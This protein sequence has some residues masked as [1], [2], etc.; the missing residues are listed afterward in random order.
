[1][2]ARSRERA[3]WQRELSAYWQQHP[4]TYCEVRFEGCFG[5]YGLS[6]AHS[7]KRFDI[8]TKQEFFEVVAAC[9]KCHERLDQKMS[10]AE[11]ERTVKRIIE[12]REVS[13]VSA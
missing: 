11:M 6:P 1:M 9:Q 7:K 4:I 10:H 12:Q 8:E 2:S 13:T 3:R 5:T